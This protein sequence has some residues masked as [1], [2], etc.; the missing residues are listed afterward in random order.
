MYIVPKDHDSQIGCPSD[1]R[2]PLCILRLLTMSR[3]WQRRVWACYYAG[4]CHKVMMQSACSYY[5][6]TSRK[7]SVKK[8]PLCDL[9]SVSVAVPCFSPPRRP[10]WAELE[11]MPWRFENQV[12]CLLLSRPAN[13]WL[14]RYSAVA[15][16]YSQ[17]ITS[18]TL[19]NRGWGSLATSYLNIMRIIIYE[20]NTSKFCMNTRILANAGA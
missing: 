9:S 1:L 5:Y 4:W 19:T 13:S 8:C 10:Q 12:T 2:P 18:G 17:T 14:P 15:V 7:P 11:N 6:Y 16:K 20:C 3:T